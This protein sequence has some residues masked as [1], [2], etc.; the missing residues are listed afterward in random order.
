MVAPAVPKHACNTHF[1]V[2]VCISRGF[3]APGR[4]GVQQERGVEGIGDVRPKGRRVTGS[5]AKCFS[6]SV[7]AVCPFMSQASLDG[8]GV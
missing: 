3:C 4:Q 1:V 7:A 5:A 6:M 8:G 2:F